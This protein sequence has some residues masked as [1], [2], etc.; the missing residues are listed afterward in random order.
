MAS[1]NPED[2]ADWP[3]KVTTTS[4]ANLTSYDKFTEVMNSAPD[5]PQ[6]AIVN[7]ERFMAF[8]TMEDFNKKWGLE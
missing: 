8:M 5:K 6:H 2:F 7:D 4:K 3:G 1:G